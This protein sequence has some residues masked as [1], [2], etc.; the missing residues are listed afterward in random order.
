M[1]GGIIMFDQPTDGN[2]FKSVIQSAVGFIAH[3]YFT[4]SL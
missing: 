4:L 3:F 2:A 1:Q